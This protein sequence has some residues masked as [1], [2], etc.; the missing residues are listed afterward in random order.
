[1][2]YVQTTTH[3]VESRYR[4]LWH[5]C[6]LVFLAEVL[7]L[8]QTSL[9]TI[10]GTV[11]DP[12]GAGIPGVRRTLADLSTNISRTATVGE[13]GNFEFA[14]VMNGTYRLRAEAPGFQAYVADNLIL[15]S[16]QIRRVDIS[17][18]VGDNKT[19][20]TVRADAAVIEQEDS[21]VSSS[22]DAKVYRDFP[23][24]A[25]VGFL[26]TALL[27]TMPGVQP[28]ENAF[29]VAIA[30]VNGQ[31]QEGMDGATTEGA[32]NQIQNMENVAE[33]KVVISNNS[34]EFARAGY[35][36]LVGERGVNALHGKLYYYHLNSALNARGFF[37][38]GKALRK[39]HTFG[40]SAGGPIRKNRTFYYA[41][42]NAQRDPAKTWYIRS[43]PT[44][45]M[46]TGDFSELSTLSKPLLIKDPTSNVPFPENRIPVTRLSALSQKVQDTYLPA[47][48]LGLPGTFSN[49]FA[50]LHPYPLDLY[51]VDF[52]EG[53]IDHKIS[54]NN[55]FF[56][57]LSQRW[58]PYVLASGWPDLAWTRQRYAWQMVFSDTHIFSPHLV[59]TLR[60]GWYKNNADDGNTVDGYTPPHGDQI[61][62]QLGLQ[63]VNPD[64][65]SAQ[66]F[67]TMAITGYTSLR[68][69]PGGVASHD[70][71]RQYAEALT[72]VKGRHTLKFGGEV[73]TYT[74]LNGTVPEGTYGNFTFAGNWSGYAYA[75]FL[76]GI[77]TQSQRLRPLINRV[78]RSYE[79]GYYY[80]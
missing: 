15:E 42:Y 68:T 32:F 79:A 35:F 23:Q 74:T 76:L 69:Q 53:R 55:D 10:R 30:G 4:R 72:W 16:S 13:S 28:P 12:T 78:P 57:R 44:T 50:F 77:P 56:G 17:M 67:P 9:S 41:G 71:Y 38:P 6:V 14:N 18:S 80:T 45:K 22:F 26:P 66:G 11:T 5:T 39:F 49:N 7:C 19:E 60:F 37:D 24:A 3:L 40:A 29:N 59:N 1:M 64:G 47:P 65:L 34:A 21:K 2:V 52:F 48:N 20:I 54:Q 46:R 43:V 62:K 73:K 51:K 36:D 27:A 58:T 75:D 61:V 33:V 70:N 63:G 8:A 25:N 31:V